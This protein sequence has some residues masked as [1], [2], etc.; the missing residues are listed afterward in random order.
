M[1]MRLIP[2][3]LILL[4]A[5]SAPAAELPLMPYPQKIEF[6]SGPS[7]AVVFGTP[8]A[9]NNKWLLAIVAEEPKPV[10]EALDRFAHRIK[11]QMGKQIGWSASKELGAQFVVRVAN[12]QPM[13]NKLEAWDESYRLTISA[14]KIELS[15]PQLLG[16]LRGLE[17]LL[18]LMGSNQGN[19]QIN[20]EIQLPPLTIVDNPRFTWRGL[21]LDT[22]RHFFSVKTI[23]RLLDA[24]AAAKYNVF[25]WHLTDDQGWRL[26]SKAFPRLQQL[27]SNG[28]YYTRQQIQEI[29]AYARAHGIQVLPEIDM[30]GHASAIAVA[31]PEWMSASG[32]YAMEYRWGVHKPTLNPVDDSV[33]R[34]IDGLVA[35]LVELFPFEYIH[36][37]GDEVDPEQWNNNPDI[38]SFMQQHRLQDSRDLQAHFNQKVQDILRKHHRKMMGWDEIQHP[39][40]S[41]DVV[42]QS[43]QGPDAIRDAASH[44][45]KSVLS[46]GFYLDQPQTAAYH[47]RNDPLPPVP[48]SPDFSNI[49]SWQS[50]YFEMPRKRGRAVTGVFTLVESDDASLTRSSGVTKTCAS[51]PCAAVSE[52][53][54]F[55]DFTGK[56]RR[57]L[58]LESYSP[59]AA[60]FSLD[61]W[62]G[63][64]L[65]D[66]RMSQEELQGWA[67]VGN[68]PYLLSGKRV[69]GSDHPNRHLPAAQPTQALNPQEEALILG[70]EAALW[71]EI[72]DEQSIDLRLWPRAFAVAERLWSARDQRDENSLYDRLE[73][74]MTW[75]RKSVGIQDLREQNTALKRLAGRG[76]I[77]PLVILAEALEPAH[78]Y[79]RQHEKSANETYSRKDPLNR[80][81]DALPAENLLSRQMQ[82][83]VDQWGATGD[84][85]AEKA[86]RN[87]FM[88]WSSNEKNLSR[89]LTQRKDLAG[90]ENLASNV[91]N[92]SVLA[93]ES[94]DTCILGQRFSHEQLQSSARLFEAARQLDQ[95]MVISVLPAVQKMVQITVN[96]P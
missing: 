93:L 17:T 2:S 56:S 82:S 38:Q 86:L 70:G 10:R 22:S 44:G 40:L 4:I 66:V 1:T 81:V 7:G 21:L 87:Q 48:V 76:D 41:R 67:R 16:V 36:M 64:V 26:A 9:L 78:Y 18:Q 13:A 59:V 45:Y 46:T 37:G 3:L 15:A 53:R 80:L 94:L 60:R 52:V 73:T 25:H 88:R 63:P 92:L 27:A 65:F 8:L 32:P 75:A 89:L 68:A 6:V 49:G 90:L 34:F 47:Y 96:C 19:V 42:I 43:W 72:V 57:E 50:W 51:K 30:P 28:D 20:N 29:V 39:G 33:Y 5:V 74:T 91:K 69:A 77:E 24:M 12:T 62:M 58:V 83:W 84:K 35:E 14:Q 61:T 71:T 11:N 31:Y 85:Q 55:I 23:K 79:H 54:G 95:E